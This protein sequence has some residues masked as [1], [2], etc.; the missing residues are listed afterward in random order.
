MGNCISVS[1]GLVILSAQA[2]RT[3]G[4]DQSKKIIGWKGLRVKAVRFST[5][6]IM[7][8]FGHVNDFLI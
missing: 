2:E 5:T 8:R 7:S 1:F 3:S 6:I 4:K